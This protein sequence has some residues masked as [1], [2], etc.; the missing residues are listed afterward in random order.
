VSERIDLEVF[1]LAQS[2]ITSLGPTP[3]PPRCTC[4]HTKEGHDEKTSSCYYCDCR[5]YKPSPE[6]A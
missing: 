6:T 3:A 1:P 2:F 4:G 5:K